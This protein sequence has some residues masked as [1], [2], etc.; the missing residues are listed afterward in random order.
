MS[1]T[2]LL[3]DLDGCLVDS[4][5]SIRGC[6]ERTLADFGAPPPAPD[7]LRH[8]AGPPV[9]EV[10]RR[11]LPGASDARIA[12][13]VAAYRRCS[14]AGAGEVPAYPGVPELLHALRGRGLRLAIA[15]SKSI[16]VAV[17]VLRALGLHRCFDVVE[18]TGV[19]EL[20]ASK[21]AVV[22]RALAGLAP[23]RPLALVGDRAHDVVGAH[24]HGL[25]AYGA[26]WGYGGRAEL[27]DA[28]AD[29]LLASPAD[30]L[31]LLE[32]SGEDG[33]RARA[34]PSR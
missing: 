8:L 9:D 11:L 1:A 18:G 24:A 15:T 31:G 26:L 27:T 33:A 5:A 12:E 21:S 10:A 6:W 16:E 17:P 22:E 23:H 28:G 14:V 13:V 7:V 32:D 29:A 30:V 2:A 34:T 19:D 3:F 25:L 4:L 20:G